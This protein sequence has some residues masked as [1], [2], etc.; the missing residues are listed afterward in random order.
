MIEVYGSDSPNAIVVLALG[1]GHF[2]KWQNYSLPSLRLYCSRNNLNLLAQVDSLDNS[3]SRKK[4]TWQKFLIPKS[5]KENFPKIKNFCYIDTDI[6][7]NPF[8]ESI[9]DFI[10]D[11]SIC[12]VSQFTNLPYSDDK[13]LRR[14]AFFRNLLIDTNYPLDSSLF[15][16][17][18]DI[19]AHHDFFEFND[20]ACAGMYMANVE[21]CY[22]T[23]E[24]VYHKY[25][26]NFNTIT[27]GDEPVFNFEIQKNFKVN[28]LPYRFQIL[29]NH[30]MAYK[31]P[32]LYTDFME[33]SSAVKFSILS[34]IMDGVFLHFAGNGY[35]KKAWEFSSFVVEKDYLSVL[36]KYNKYINTP[37]TGKPKGK[38]KFQ[39]GEL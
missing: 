4:F 19:Y 33:N 27:E 32:F 35:E 36:E 17:P 16:K 3:D 11:S 25:S 28:W 22:K 30:E 13:I 24:S 9:F 23:L 34:S 39:L 21:Y 31:Y 15:M 12:L 38:F 37:V 10:D 5:V 14:I 8:A 6:I 20:Y 29:W 2:E 7:C 26:N 18:K 1:P